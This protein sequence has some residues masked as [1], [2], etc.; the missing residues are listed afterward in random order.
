MDSLVH[1]FIRVV[2]SAAFP[3]PLEIFAVIRFADFK[4]FW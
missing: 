1:F 3:F 4:K 2:C